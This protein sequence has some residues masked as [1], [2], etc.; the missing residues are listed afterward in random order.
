M[1]GIVGAISTKNIVPVL[2]EGLKR[3]EYRGY[4][5]CGVAVNADAPQLGQAAGLQRARSTSRVAELV[6]QVK[7]DMQSLWLQQK[8]RYYSKPLKDL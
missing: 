6:A 3:L 1:C 7:M 4:D 2:I 5:S 8:K